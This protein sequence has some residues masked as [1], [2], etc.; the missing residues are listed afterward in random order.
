MTKYLLRRV[1]AFSTIIVLVSM[2]SFFLIHLLPG[3]VAVQIAGIGAT[4]E[5]T[6]WLYKHLGLDQPIYVQ[7]YHW[8][9]P[10]LHGDLG[11]SPIS[12]VPVVSTIGN[13]LP[14]DVGL[15]VMSQI[16]ALGVAIPLA[17][18]SARKPNSIFDRVVTSSS[19]TLLAVPSF[20]A[21]VLLDLVFVTWLHLDLLG[22]GNFNPVVDSPWMSLLQWRNILGMLLGSV[23]LALGSVVVY[24]R[25]MR[26]VM[27]G[28]MQEEFVTVARSKGI[29][30]RRILWRH[31]FR[32]STIPLLGVISISIGG[33]VA[34][35]FV[36]ESLLGLPGLG[37]Q[38]IIAVTKKDYVLVQGIT[39]VISVIVV[40]CNFFLDFLYAFIDPRIARE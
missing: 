39:L 9:I 36:V 30:R 3:N 22:P 26:G 12:R 7:Y 15:S 21:I 13:A 40:A 29:S 35:G 8:L 31:V 28:T 14:I 33:L 2:G 19:F 23:T 10:V 16:L 24:Y 20:V 17:M 18:R 27:I 38:L 11:T 5:Y 6:A 25:V 4:P 1:A 32:S 34:G 37:L